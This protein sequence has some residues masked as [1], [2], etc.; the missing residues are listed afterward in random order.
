MVKIERKTQKIFANNTS[1]NQI[2]SFG[3]AKTTNPEYTTDVSEIQTDTYLQGWA[4]SLESDLAP[5]MQDSNGLW[6]MATK[7]LAYLF[8]EGIAEWD[9]ETE[10][11][12]G[13]LVKVTTGIYSNIYKSITDNNIAHLTNDTTYWSLYI[14]DSN[15]AHYPIGDIR[16]SLNNSKLANEIFLEGQIVSRTTYASLFKIFG[17]TYGAGDGSTTFALPNFTNRV[18][19]GSTNANGYI[20]AGLPNI[21]GGAWNIA[22]QSRDVNDVTV[23]GC[24]VKHTDSGSGYGTAATAIHCDGFEFNANSGAVASNIYRDNCYTVQPPAIKVRVKTRWY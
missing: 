8:Q 19:W 17:T 1:A 23:S 21:K 6:Y 20:S 16:F 13:S 14:A 9:S 22:A 15:M 2:T 18:A 4:P 10:Y 24:C 11:N 5:F 7:Q 12:K 3:T